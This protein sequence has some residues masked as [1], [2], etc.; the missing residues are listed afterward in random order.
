MEVVQHSAAPARLV[1]Q[2]F[3]AATLYLV[4]GALGVIWI[5]P[6]LAHGMYLAPRVAAV[7]HLFTLGWLTLT[8]LG[9]LGQLLPMA[10]GAPIRSLWLA[11]A[12]LWIL[13]P[14]VAVFAAGV[15]T[16]A[17]PLLVAGVVCVAL[18]VLLA[19]THVGTTLVRSRARDVTWTAI[20]L[21]TAFLA[22]TLGLGLVLAHN[23]H[24]G[25]VAAAR[26]RILAAHLHVALVGWALIIVVG[27][28]RRLLPMFL[29]AQNADARWTRRA[30]VLLTAGVPVLATGLVAASAVAN[31]LGAILLA[32]GTGAYLWQALLFYR[33]R[34]RRTL[35]V[36]MR[37]VVAGLPFFG[38]A[39]MVGPVVLALGGAHGRWATGYVVTALLGGFVPF[40][41]G[42]LYE[43]VPT[44]AWT[45]RFAGRL[46]RGR[47]PAVTQLYSWP[48]AMV[49]L[50]MTIAG[51]VLML[52]GIAAAASIVVRAGALLF[53][54]AMLVFG[55][56]VARMWWGTPT[57]PRSS[58]KPS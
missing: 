19:V 42:F 32:L 35:D 9:A 33:A 54:T 24:S 48:L 55:S 22:S 45:A 58:P 14:G 53:L 11:R 38:A 6:E 20:A 46:N 12:A 3:A 39:V 40:V 10:L 34:T 5:A 7:T 41:T 25:F 18:G 43:I 15:A 47:V 49:Q 57:G 56:Q 23:L 29:V 2:H 27:V 50:T 13:A 17:T 1:S 36:G 31:W 52:G 30:L 16:A 28:S 21:G 4:A 51:V 37:F 8:I 44:L 26:V